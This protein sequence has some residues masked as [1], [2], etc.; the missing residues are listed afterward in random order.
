MLISDGFWIRGRRDLAD[1]HAGRAVALLGDATPSR[2][3]AWVLVRHAAR[4][5]LAGD[6]ELGAEL[7]TRV[8]DLAEA[9]GWAEGQS[10]ALGVLG[11]A[12]VQQGDR[13]GLDDIARAIEISSTA[14][15]LGALANAYNNL[16]VGQQILGDLDAGHAAR[17]DGARVADRLDSEVDKRWFASVLVDHRYRRGEWDEALRAAD[18]FVEAVDAGSPHYNAW[19]F[20]AIRAEIRLARDDAGGAVTDAERALEIGRSVADPQAVYF[21]LAACAHVFA[22]AGDRDRAV[23]LARELLAA[24]HTGVGIQF[25]V[26]ELPAFVSVAAELGV[27]GQLAHALEARSQTRWTAAARSYLDGDFSAAAEILGVIGARP[28]EAEARLRSAERLA[29]D[30][31]PAEADEELRRAAGFFGSVGASR[32]L[33]ECEAVLQLT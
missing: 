23:R 14:G 31:R 9:L 33:R 26:I 10:D 16:A 25:A 8:R 12:R 20:H 15:A 27:A 1:E 2:A 7:G 22:R 5:V 13:R 17:L 18:A 32:Y 28:E 6:I 30:G 29:A 4:A 3:S 21:V 19:Q 11:I 24:L